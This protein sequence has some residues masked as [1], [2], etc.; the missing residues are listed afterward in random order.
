MGL[1]RKLLRRH[2]ENNHW[3]AYYAVPTFAGF[4]FT[5]LFFQVSVRIAPGL[6]LYANGYHIHHYTYGIVILLISGYVGIWAPS[7]ESKNICAFAH[8]VGAALIIDEAWIWVTLNPGPGYQDYDLAFF[9]AALILSVALAP[10][11]FGKKRDS[12]QNLP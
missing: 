3:H 4:L 12:S 7:I 11:L 6:A 10:L 1:I 2:Q 5:Y 8:G 9:V